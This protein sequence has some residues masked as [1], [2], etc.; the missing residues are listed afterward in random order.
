MDESKLLALIERGVIALEAI[1][2]QSGGETVPTAHEPKAEQTRKTLMHRFEGQY[3][4][5][6][7]ARDALGMHGTSSKAVGMVV[8][9]AGFERKRWATGVRFAICE[10]G[11][12]CTG[13]PVVLPDNLDDAAQ[14]AKEAKSKHGRKT[15]P[16]Q[17]LYGAYLM[18]GKTVK[19][20]QVTPQHIA[21][22]KRLYPGLFDA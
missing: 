1:A 14:M 13:A 20:S 5:I 2:Q 18:S 12:V 21:E 16:E 7:Q 17:V 6:E 10:P 4:S 9:A 22:V 3:I 11:G 8:S 15:T 19:P